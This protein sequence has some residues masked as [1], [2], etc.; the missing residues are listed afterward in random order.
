VAGLD[1]TLDLHG[2]FGWM[3]QTE[4]RGKSDR[5]HWQQRPSR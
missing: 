2:G 4:Q 3:A 5:K 1:L